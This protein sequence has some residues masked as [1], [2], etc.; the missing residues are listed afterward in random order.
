MPPV[1]RNEQIVRRVIELWNRSTPA[2]EGD[3]DA[4]LAPDVELDLS[5]RV[6]NPAVYSGRDGFRRLQR[7][8]AELW[9]WFRMEP[10]QVLPSGEKVVV[11]AHSIG[12]G[13]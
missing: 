4:L 10:E 1:S 6:L 8:V 2:G 11:L 9:E 3:F 7:E 5:D 13:R 12:R